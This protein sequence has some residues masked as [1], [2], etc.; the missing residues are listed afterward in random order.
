MCYLFDL[1]YNIIYSNG[2]HV[3]Q[4][5]TLAIKSDMVLQPTTFEIIQ[6][7]LHRPPVPHDLVA[8]EHLVD[9]LNK[10]LNRPLSLV[11]APAGYGK[12][13]LVSSWLENCD[14]PS[15]WLS[16][17]ETDNDLHLFLSYILTTIRTIFPEVGKEIQTILKGQELPAVSFL[18]GR[19]VN[20]LDKIDTPFILTIDDYHI[21][22]NDA[23]H[24][25]LAG[26]LNH[27]PHAM[28]LVLVSRIDPP[29]PLT[30]LRAKGY[31]TEVRVS[32][33][34]FSRKETAEYLGQILETTIEE[35]IVSIF[36]EKAEGWITGLRLATLSLQHKDDI[37][38]VVASLP[39]ANR[40]ILD[41]FVEEILS[42]QPEAIQDWLLATSVLD[43][44]C[45]PLCEAVVISDTTPD[46]GGING[47]VFLQLL[48]KSNLFVIHL[49]DE[50]RWFR[51]HHL[52]KNLLR[53]RIKH[54]FTRDDIEVIHTRV[55]TWFAENGHF[56]EAIQHAL[57]GGGIGRAAEIVG[58]A[59]HNLMNSDQW[60]RLARWLKLFSNESILQYPHLIL[61]RCWLDYYQW[62]HLDDMVKDL[63]QADLLLGTYVF[64]A[65]EVEPLQAEVAALHSNL[66]YWFLNP[67]QGIELVEQA[68]R[69]SPDEHE[70]T[71]TTATFAWGPLYQML[72]EAR[73]G[74]RIVRDYTKDGCYSHPSSQTRIMQSLCILYWP[75][76]ETRKLQQTASRLLEISLERELSWN[77]SFA[78]Y[79]LGL[80]HY[81]QNELNEAVEHLKI[82]VDEPYLF[83][84]QNLAHCSY[85]LSL[86]YQALGLSD[87]ALEVAQSIARLAFERGNEM[88]IDLSEAFLAELDLHQGRIAQVEKWAST[89]VVPPPHGMP[90]FFNTELTSIRIMIALN[91]PKSLKSATDQ[92]DS[93]HKLMIEINHPRLMIDVL[94][95]QALLADTL[96]HDS[97]ALKKLI[98]ALALAEPGG[99]I[100]PFLDLGQH[101]VELLRRLAN[102]NS[103]AEFTRRI[104]ATLKN[105][106]TG[107]DRDINDNQNVD[108][109]AL[110]N[111]SLVDP[112]TNREI[113]ILLVL[114][115]RLSNFEIAE[116]LF[117]SPETVKRHLYNIYQKLG[118]E[119][120]MQAVAKAR[121]LGMA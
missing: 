70:C 109:I 13:T 63:A 119:N 65:G 49:D 71:R 56:E 29:L 30:T 10:R 38:R 98:E 110:S 12:S 4:E 15:V 81:E 6:T 9:R 83:P 103:D 28:H 67:S 54:R 44:F 91:T 64:N 80:V 102:Q 88:F 21:I 114:S 86:S 39:D 52:F 7:K 73:K 17:D 120:R 19:F 69:N 5:S 60:H 118:V 94:G 62:Y 24:E 33:L 26:I 116:K 113:E 41:Y 84:I 37:N 36:D 96:G 76:G 97:T 95:L 79:F 87:Q 48:K 16:L 20:E 14:L 92:L 11:S 34:R 100:R 101:M 59:R 46:N 40:F 115:E 89:F 51:Y 112:L 53:R 50:G 18:T 75:E 58:H 3:L 2:I 35:N 22:Q 23:V 85:L 43:R 72:G 31:M 90:R 78:R 42:Q 107:L 108:R 57:A 121:S 47:Q 105:E 104:L 82:I 106:E 74:E 32:D 25:L 8:R 61:L 99:F 66:A 93:M 111:Q 68:L 1:S 45:A 77:Q 27:P 55:S 117:I